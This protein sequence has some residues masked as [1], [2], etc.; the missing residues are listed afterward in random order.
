M[1]LCIY[2]RMYDLYKY[3]FVFKEKIS[4]HYFYFMF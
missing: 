3:I 1:N 4:L 2:F